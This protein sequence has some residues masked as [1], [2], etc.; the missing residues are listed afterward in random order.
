MVAAAVFDL[1]GNNDNLQRWVEAK[2][3]RQTGAGMVAYDALVA[4]TVVPAPCVAGTYE[5]S[6]AQR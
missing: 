6:K 1:M 4:T 2:G 5:S 3:Q